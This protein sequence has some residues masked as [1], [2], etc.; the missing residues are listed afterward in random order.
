MKAAAIS[1]PFGI[2]TATRAGYVKPRAARSKCSS[3]TNSPKP[4][5][6]S[7]AQSAP[8]IA[9]RFA[10]CSRCC[11]KTCPIVI[12]VFSGGI[13]NLALDRYL[14]MDL[15]CDGDDMA[16]VHASAYLKAVV[17]WMMMNHVLPA[18]FA[19]NCFKVGG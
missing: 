2:T 5:Y 17:R 12:G 10:L 15:R 1:G 9:M 16:V 4:A 3:S 14:G 13:F 7:G 18:V 8:A 19:I 6:V 11:R